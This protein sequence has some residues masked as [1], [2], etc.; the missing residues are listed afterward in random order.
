MIKK[1]HLEDINEISLFENGSFIVNKIKFDFS[2]RN[3]QFLKQIIKE[4]VLQEPPIVLRSNSHQNINKDEKE[5]SSS[6]KIVNEKDNNSNTVRERKQ[7]IIS[8]NIILNINS[9]ITQTHNGSEVKAQSHSG[10]S[11]VPNLYNTNISQKS[12]SNPISNN[13]ININI[14]PQNNL[15]KH[16]ENN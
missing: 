6:F 10:L 2:F 14:P 4:K 8:Q 12:N 11:F 13:L 15:T 3:R 16:N 9:P 7:E 1:E 5:S